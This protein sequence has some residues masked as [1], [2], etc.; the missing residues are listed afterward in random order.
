MRTGITTWL[1]STRPKNCHLSA[2]RSRLGVGEI[3]DW[4]ET[5]IGR[6]NLYFSV[7]EPAIDAPNGKLGKDEIGSIRALCLDHDPAAAPTGL[8]PDQLKKHFEAER[9]RLQAEYAAMC[10]GEVPPTFTVDSGGGY[11]ALWLLAKKLDRA[12]HMEQIEAQGRAIK[13]ALGGDAVHNVDRIM[14][15]P[16]TLN[17]PTA[18]KRAK[19]QYE[20]RAAVITATG[21]RYTP[22]ELAKHH[23]PGPNPV[24]TAAVDGDDNSAPNRKGPRGN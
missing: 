1:R 2:A 3:A 5:Y 17:V 6:R 7:N 22:D 24:S 14:R 16:G 15:L 12:E 21:A 4:I 10:G 20:R 11:Q 23:P 13:R 19:G 8:S 9:E 18:K